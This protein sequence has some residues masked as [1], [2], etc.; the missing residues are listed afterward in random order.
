EVAGRALDDLR[1]RRAA[2]VGDRGTGQELQL[3]DVMRE[4]RLEVAGRRDPGTDVVVGVQLLLGKRDREEAADARRR[5]REAELT[6]AA[7]IAEGALADRRD[8]RHVGARRR[9]ALGLHDAVRAVVRIAAVEGRTV[10]LQ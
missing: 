3:L 7:Q 1:R 4:A 5:R 6:A 10:G 2:D 9:A 8:R